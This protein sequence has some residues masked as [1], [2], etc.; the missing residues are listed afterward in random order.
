[1]YTY[2]HHVFLIIYHKNSFDRSRKIP[3]YAYGCFSF[4]RSLL[5]LDSCYNLPQRKR[6]DVD[7]FLWV[8]QFPPLSKPTHAS[9]KRATSS[10]VIDHYYVLPSP[11]KLCTLFYNCI[12]NDS[13]TAGFQVEQIQAGTVPSLLPSE[14]EIYSLSPSSDEVTGDFELSSDFPELG[15]DDAGPADTEG[16]IIAVA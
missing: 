1:M 9:T 3:T 15:R 12:D 8:L 13:L 4:I 16:E 10:L 6:N 5:L 14:Q 11:N 2:V 7:C